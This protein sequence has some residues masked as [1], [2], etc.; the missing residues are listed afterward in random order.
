VRCQASNLAHRRAKSIRP[1]LI[2]PMD[3]RY[4]NALIQLFFHILSLGLLVV[5][6]PK[7]RSN[8]F[9]TPSDVR[10]SV[11]GS[12]HRCCITVDCM[13]AGHLS[14]QRLLR[15]GLADIRGTP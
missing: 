12:A 10:R 11:P 4:L 1:G 13:L 5:A 15:T 8:Y 7:S 6:W 2:N 9:R 14:W 3:T